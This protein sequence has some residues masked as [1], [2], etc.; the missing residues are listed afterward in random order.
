MKYIKW[1]SNFWTIIITHLIIIK[2]YFIILTLIEPKSF[3]GVNFF[4]CVNT[5]AKTLDLDPN[6]DTG[7]KEDQMIE[8]QKA[9]HSTGGRGRWS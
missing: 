3:T 1:T 5:C 6:A 7:G 8:T 9:S 2:C 4:Q